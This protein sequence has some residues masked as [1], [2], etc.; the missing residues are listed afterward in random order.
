K[1]IDIE[2][3]YQVGLADIFDGG[4]GYLNFRAM[5]THY[6][7][8]IVDNRVTAI[9]QAGSNEG[10]TPDWKYRLLATYTLEPWTFNVTARGVSD[11]V[12]SNSYIECSSN[13]PPSS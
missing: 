10:P 3:S 7:D 4:D 13:C 8:N 6:I 9:D 11:G 2:A 12:I 5:A 1:G